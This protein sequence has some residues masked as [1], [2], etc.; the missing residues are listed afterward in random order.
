METQNKALYPGNPETDF[1]YYSTPAAFHTWRAYTLFQAAE[2]AGLL[3]WA[4]LNQAAV[5]LANE[6]PD[7]ALR[8]VPTGPVRT[9]TRLAFWCACAS[10]YLGLDRGSTTYWRPFEE[11]FGLAPKTLSRATGPLCL[12]RDREGWPTGLE[13][14]TAEIDPF[15]ADLDSEAS[16]ADS[17]QLADT[18]TPKV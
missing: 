8:P 14:Y 3:Q 9:Q 10:N 4:I 7:F 13:A 17:Q 6:D 16:G 18:S 15:F 1:F 12:D 5:D 2:R 11:L